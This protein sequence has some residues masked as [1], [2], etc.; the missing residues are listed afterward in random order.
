M[1]GE[2]C[3]SDWIKTQI[4]GCTFLASTSHRKPQPFARSSDAKMSASTTARTLGCT[5]RCYHSSLDHR[6][7]CMR[8]SQ[9]LRPTID[10]GTT[11]AD[12]PDPKTSTSTAK[13]CRRRSGKPPSS[14]SPDYHQATHHSALR[15]A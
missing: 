2:F 11:W 8:L 14:H 10:C 15:V 13:P 4:T 3:T 6:V 5:R 9:C 1:T 7:R 12:Y